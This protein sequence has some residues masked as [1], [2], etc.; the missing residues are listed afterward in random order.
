[1]PER[2]GIVVL[3]APRSGTTLLRRIL[4]AHPR[5]SCPGETN[6]FAAC[7]RYLRTDTN[8]DGLKIGVLS[9]LSFMG[10][11]E[12]EA[13][14]RLRDLVLSFLRDHAKSQ[15]KPRWAEKSAFD[16]FHI[17]TVERLVEARAH[18]VCVHRHGLDVALSLQDLCDKAGYY[19]SELM[20][21]LRRY[22][23]PLEAFTRAWVDVTTELL[24]FTA[25]HPDSSVMIRYEDLVSEPNHVI[26]KILD[27]VG[28]THPSDLLDKALSSRENLGLGDWKT[29]GRSSIEPGSIGRWNSLSRNAAST[30]GEIANPVLEATGYE[31]VPV[32]PR[33]SQQD[34]QKGYKMGLML[35]RAREE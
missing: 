35:Q 27:F 4:D 16:S 21:Y 11:A 8:A 1:M 6:L 7:D 33:R 3:G 28:E 19:A 14:E 10:V 31:T 30:L 12:E 2:E 20:P 23:R 26:G 15:G 9:G 5:I 22:P 17:P 18:F 34:A 25:R 24:A 32:V 13:I 29:Y